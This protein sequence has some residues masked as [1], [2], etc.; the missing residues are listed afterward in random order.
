MA[1]RVSRV[2]TIAAVASLRAHRERMRNARRQERLAQIR[3]Y[4]AC[5]TCG[6]RIVD[7][8]PELKLAQRVCR[9]CPPGQARLAYQPIDEEATA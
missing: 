2:K 7:Q 8:F 9:N 4:L 6:W 3:R 5:S 1:R